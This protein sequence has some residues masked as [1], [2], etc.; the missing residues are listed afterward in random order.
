LCGICGL[1]YSPF[2]FS[3]PAIAKGQEWRCLKHRFMV[4]D[5]WRTRLSVLLSEEELGELIAYGARKT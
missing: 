1:K 2:G 4:G 3:P 5:E